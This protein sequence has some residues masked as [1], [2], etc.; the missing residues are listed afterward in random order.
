MLQAPARGISS[1]VVFIFKKNQAR[2]N[3][4]YEVSQDVARRQCDFERRYPHV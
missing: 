2:E 3:R 1:S 4:R